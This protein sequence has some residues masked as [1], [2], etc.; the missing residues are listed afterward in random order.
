M[1]CSASRGTDRTTRRSLRADHQGAARE[2]H[3]ANEC[4]CR[5][6]LAIRRP[7]RASHRAR[8]PSSRPCHQSE[9]GRSRPTCGDRRNLGGP[10]HNG[11]TL[12]RIDR[13]QIELD[14]G[15]VEHVGAEIE[16]VDEGSDACSGP[17]AVSAEATAVPHWM[18]SAL[19]RDSDASAKPCERRRA[20]LAGRNIGGADLL[21]ALRR[22]WRLRSP[23]FQHPVN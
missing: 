5:S 22:E 11:D 7:A 8:N 6:A 19:P 3:S 18:A 1:C 17:D 9:H 12:P 10:P 23:H 16:R 20:A 14:C 15:R 21:A 2:V 4:G 13:A